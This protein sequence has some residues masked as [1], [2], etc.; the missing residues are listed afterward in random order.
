MQALKTREPRFINDLEFLIRCMEAIGREHQVT[1][2]LLQQ[3]L[4]DIDRNRVPTAIKVPWFDSVAQAT[5]PCGH[6]IPLL[7][8]SSVSSHSKIQPPLPGRL[9]LK[10]PIGNAFGRHTHDCCLPAPW[11]YPP[12]SMGAPAGSSLGDD[13]SGNKRRRMQSPEP[14]SSTSAAANPMYSPGFGQSSAFPRG[15]R[16]R[17]ASPTPVSDFLRVKLVHRMGSSASSPS[18]TRDTPSTQAESSAAAAS[19]PTP[20]DD[21]DPDGLVQAAQHTLA[22]LENMFADIENW[23]LTEPSAFMEFM[24]AARM[25]GGVVAAAEG[26]PWNVLGNWDPGAGGGPSG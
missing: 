25:A 9:P 16:P 14:A 18:G 24:D 13:T 1:R 11:S 26:D 17:G 22:G 2:S 7:A 5:A 20:D 10:K 12:K 8:R 19:R 21:P 15:E 4:L 6:N 3:A 23:D